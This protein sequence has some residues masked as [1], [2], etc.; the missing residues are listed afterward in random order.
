MYAE[1]D[2]RHATVR[3]MEVIPIVGGVPSA[4]HQ[5]VVDGI[6]VLDSA[7]FQTLFA[8]HANGNG[9]K[10]VTRKYTRRAKPASAPAKPAEPEAHEYGPTTEKILAALKDGPLTSGEIVKRTGMTTS[11]VYSTLSVLRSRGIVRSAECDED[12][13]RKNWLVTK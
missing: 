12:G 3:A 13:V 1:Y 8:P 10:P 4:E 11:C 5:F 2:A 7:T 9:T 6:G